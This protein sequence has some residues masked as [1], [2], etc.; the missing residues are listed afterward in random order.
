MSLSA[1]A[2]G[3]CEASFQWREE[4]AFQRRG[5]LEEKGFFLFFCCWFV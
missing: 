4:M 3:K 5:N 2:V 1:L